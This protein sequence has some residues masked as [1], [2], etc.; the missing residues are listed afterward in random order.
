[1]TE[2]E[3]I[4]LLCRYFLTP[5]CLFILWAAPSQK[6]HARFTRGGAKNRTF[7]YFNGTNPATGKGIQ[8]QSPNP[9]MAPG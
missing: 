6:M 7:G 9:I 2:I 1:M 8:L 3:F 4:H 5:F